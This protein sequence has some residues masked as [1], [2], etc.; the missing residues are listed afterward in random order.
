MARIKRHVRNVLDTLPYISSLRRQVNEQGF[1]PAGHYYSPIPSREDVIA[2]LGKARP[3]SSLAGIELCKESQFALLQQY[4]KY[5]EEAPFPLQKRG[6]CRYYYEQDWF[7]YADAILLYCFIRHFRPKRI[8]EV[9]SG[10][11]ALIL[12]TMERFP[13]GDVEVTFIE[14]FPDRLL[15]LLKPED[16]N[17]CRIIEHKVQEVDPRVFESIQSG[18]LLFI[19]SSHVVKYGSDV[20]HLFFEILP[21]LP[22]GAYVHFHDIFFP[23]EYISEWMAEGRYWNEDYFLRAF[24]SYNETWVI[25]LF[26]H[27][28][29][30]EF[31]SYLQEKM[32]LCLKRACGSLYLTRIK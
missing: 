25:V 14:P 6:D 19:D 31:R 20:Q 3:R 32:P 4:Q 12:D 8:V 11:S 5:Y 22:K 26:N 2:N 27:Y 1:Y 15:S 30:I 9:G 10:L 17:R 13:Y 23:F 16:K 18:D 29:S 7:C 28:A 24:L 21:N